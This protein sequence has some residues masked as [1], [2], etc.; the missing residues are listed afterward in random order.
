MKLGLKQ[1]K[2]LCMLNRLDAFKL[3][4]L[5]QSKQVQIGLSNV[6]DDFL[7]MLE[8]EDQLE[9]IDTVLQVRALSN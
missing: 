1:E 5:E 2:Y 6:N 4:K 9:M 3:I 7:K 8:C